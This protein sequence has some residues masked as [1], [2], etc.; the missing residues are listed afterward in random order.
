MVK[1]FR[2]KFRLRAHV[3]VGWLQQRLF[4]ARTGRAKASANILRLPSSLPPPVCQ[5]VCAYSAAGLAKRQKKNALP[6]DRASFSFENILNS[7]F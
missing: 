6:Y 4:Q 2:Y 3:H 5:N 7:N 1:K